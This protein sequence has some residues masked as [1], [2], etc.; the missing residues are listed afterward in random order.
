M[1]TVALQAPGV[2]K[3]TTLVDISQMAQMPGHWGD[4]SEVFHPQ[5]PPVE[6]ELGQSSQGDKDPELFRYNPPAALTELANVTSETIVLIVRSSVEQVFEQVEAERRR[7]QEELMLS[8]GPVDNEP[9][10]DIA[11][12]KS[13]DITPQ[14]LRLAQHSTTVSHSSSSESQ[15][16]ADEHSKS[17]R[18]HRFGLR[19]VFQHI[20]EKGGSS[21]S[22]N[23]NGF[24]I[25]SLPAHI[26][27]ISPPASTP[28]SSPPP[29]RHSPPPPPSSFTQLVYKHIK[30]STPPHTNPSSEAETIE[31]VSCFDDLSP[32]AGV[33]TPCH[34][35]CK[36]C[37][38][39]LISTALETEAQWPPKCCLN[40]IP[41][42]TITKHAGSNLVR[43]YRDRDEEF[44][45]PVSD[46]IYCSTADCGTWIKKVDKANKTARCSAGHVMCVLCRGA[47]HPLGTACA[48][49]R[50][51]AVVDQ[52]AEEEGW[53]RCSKCAV[54][55]EHR[56]AC[57]HMTC[58]CGNEFC[59]VCGAQWRTCACTSE[60]LTGIKTRAAKKREERMKKER[61]EDTW[62]QNA[63]RLIEEYERETKEV[64][65]R[66]KRAR[67]EERRRERVKMEEERVK[68]LEE[69]YAE[70][71]ESLGRVNNM[72]RGLLSCAHEGE[73]GEAELQKERE[74]EELERRQ[75]AELKELKGVLNQKLM[76]REMEWD[77]DYR[78]RVAYEQQL[79]EGYAGALRA[80][81]MGKAGGDERLSEALG[82]YMMQ[83]DRRWDVWSKEREVNLA[84][85]K[86]EAEEEVAVRDEIM[87]TMR[88]RLETKLGEREAEREARFAA[89]RRWFELVVAERTRMLAEIEGVD[90]ESGGVGD[91]EATED[92]DVVLFSGRDDNLSKTK[93][94]GWPL[95]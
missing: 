2:P 67:R 34:T 57:Q 14:F 47:P 69:R 56:E 48:Q 52:L 40:P 61:E 12:G 66:I 7:T 74:R 42:R 29:P 79:E 31:C 49:D 38:Q 62:L 4:E 58:R 83:N 19:R 84:K 35:Y 76:E 43:R 16:W 77:R 90:R 11:T 32:K 64:E 81:W 95:P 51:R 50:D 24:D 22:S 1:C 88:S 70:L 86:F 85:A 75:G 28:G 26:H 59:Y 27:Q 33:K 54:L 92:E 73:R 8:V 55:V 9:N 65:E 39:Q 36:P 3:S 15:S 80:F 45:V 91:S 5:E 41:F 44:K 13:P 63:L 53:R 17:H 37:F 20:T 89:E 78:V 23:I 30:P 46:R 25:S 60:M 21:S 6:E 94:R 18:R 71:R 87:D 68:E 72:Q 10:E 93:P 82:A